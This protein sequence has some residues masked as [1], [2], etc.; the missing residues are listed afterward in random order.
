M[1]NQTWPLS[2]IISFFS[3]KNSLESRVQA[4]VSLAPNYFVDNRDY[5][6]F[7]E[8]NADP[9]KF[10]TVEEVVRDLAEQQRGDDEEGVS[11]PNSTRL[12]PLHHVQLELSNQR[13]T[14]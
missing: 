3:D 10:M 5:I 9:I 8:V 1:K 13:Y 7:M 11:Y 2:S 4:T 6:G 14:Y 12:L